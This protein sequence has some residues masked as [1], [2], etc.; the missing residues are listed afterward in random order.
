MESTYKFV[1]SYSISKPS[2][3]NKMIGDLGWFPSLILTR[4]NAQHLIRKACT[5]LQFTETHK[6]IMLH[7]LKLSTS[8]YSKIRIRAQDTIRLALGIF[9]YSYKIL[10][11]Y[12]IEYLRLDPVKNHDAYKV[13]FFACCKYSFVFLFF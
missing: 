3:E 2:V 1:P 13:C 9:P 4:V 7:L 11:P 12:I 6:N 10:L 5:V 8:R